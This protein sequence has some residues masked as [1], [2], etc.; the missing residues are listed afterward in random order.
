M[1]PATQSL[2]R[3]RDFGVDLD[4]TVEELREVGAP[5]SPASAPASTER[6]FDRLYEEFSPRVRGLVKKLIVDAGQ[7]EDL[8]QETFFRAYNA[9]LHFEYERAHP[10]HTQWPWLAAVARNL[11]LD[12]L[13]RHKGVT[14]EEFVLEEFT[15]E[16]PG[17][18]PDLHLLATRRREAIRDALNSVS[19]RRRRV[20][21]M[22]CVEGKTYDE[23][24]E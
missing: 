1:T 22:K 10:E 11:S 20:L 5:D 9:G 14:E 15:R 16:A 23:I 17:A 12:V 24:A 4:L 18:E 3:V 8:V 19:D 13:R 7:A 6:D 21:F 2:A